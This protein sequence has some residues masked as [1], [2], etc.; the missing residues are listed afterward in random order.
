MYNQSV[1]IL[2][3]EN[4]EKTLKDEPLFEGATLGLE[5]G[6]KAGIVGRN[7]AGKSTFLKTVMGIL[8]PD[9]GKVSQRAG[10][11][12]AYLEQAVSFSGGA[13]VRSYLY[14]SSARKI[15]TLLSYRKALD[16]I[17]AAGAEIL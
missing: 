8:T 12:M 7:G 17:R 10:T 2:S 4:L 16:E 9:E 13:T 15:Q 14:E 6:E 5:D 3:I 11:D 1:N